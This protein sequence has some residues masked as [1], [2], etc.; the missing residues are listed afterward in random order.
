MYQYVCS[1]SGFCQLCVWVNCNICISNCC[2]YA[3]IRWCRYQQQKKT[4]L[5]FWITT[6]KII[7][8]VHHCT[9]VHLPV[10]SAGYFVKGFISIPFVSSCFHHASTCGGCWLFR[11]RVYFN[12]FCFQLFS[13]CTFPWRRPAMWSMVLLSRAMSPS[14]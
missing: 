7:S 3:Y 5:F 2:H 1:N 4:P 13:S 10:A 9:I 14:R 8:A 11:K 6:K 12:T